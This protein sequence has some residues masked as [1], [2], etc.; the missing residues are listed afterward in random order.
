VITITPK[1]ITAERWAAET[2]RGLWQYGTIPKLLREDQWKT[3]AA[4]VIQIP[5]I[6]ALSPPRPEGFERWQDWA[7]QF[8]VLIRLLPV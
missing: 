7:A 8:N 3:W 5:A 1:H 4:F 6:D 2:G